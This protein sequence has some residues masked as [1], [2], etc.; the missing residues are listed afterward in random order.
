MACTEVWRVHPRKKS[1]Q[2][3]Y[4]HTPHWEVDTSLRGGHL[5][6]MALHRLVIHMCCVKL[7][8]A[9]RSLLSCIFGECVWHTCMYTSFLY[10]MYRSSGMY[11]PPRKTGISTYVHAYIYTYMNVRVSLTHTLPPA[12][13]QKSIVHASYVA[14]CTCTAWYTCTHAHMNVCISTKIHTRTDTQQIPAICCAIKWFKLHNFSIGALL[15]NVTEV[16][17]NNPE[18]MVW[19]AASESDLACQ[20]YACMCVCMYACSPCVCMY[21][22]M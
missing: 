13:L 16:I 18:H 7:R 4:H 3:K 12:Y 17:R 21:V 6:Q 20:V 5:T 11:I 19:V 1:Y 22:C 2:S 14:A 8:V 10:G 9:A 15:T